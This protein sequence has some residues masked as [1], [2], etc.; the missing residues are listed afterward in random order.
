MT[1][2]IRSRTST[3]AVKG[4]LD[5]AVRRAW[6]ITVHG[7][8]RVPPGPAIMCA[9][10]RSFMDSLFLGAVTPRRLV[11]LAKAE[12]FEHPVTARLFRALGQIPLRRGSASSARAALRAAGEIIAAGD[13]VGIYPEGTRS[14]DGALG[15]GHPGPAWLSAHT[16]APIVPA[17]IIGSERVQDPSQRLPRP[18]RPV[19]IRFGAPLEPP[20]STRGVDVKAHT[21]RLMRTIADLSDQPPPTH[22]LDH[23]GQQEPPGT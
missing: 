21:K 14:R 13:I 11:F 9:N 6:P 18:R 8:E 23:R 5:G 1:H 3:R 12:Y 2:P 22:I 7:L 15:P 16:G 20:S 17:G 4:A 10:H 19:T